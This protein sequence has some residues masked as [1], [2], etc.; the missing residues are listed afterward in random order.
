MCH[1]HCFT[2]EHTLYVLLHGKCNSKYILFETANL[3][4]A[5]CHL[6]KIKSTF[7]VPK[8]WEVGLYK[9][10]VSYPHSKKSSKYLIFHTHILKDPYMKYNVGVI[11]FSDDVRFLLNIFVTWNEVSFK[12]LREFKTIIDYYWITPHLFCYCDSLGHNIQIAFLCE[13]FTNETKKFK[14]KWAT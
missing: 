10:C 4:Y 1:N 8:P 5:L 3:F 9:T 2:E 13:F 7:F 14:P 6:Q 12:I 11:H